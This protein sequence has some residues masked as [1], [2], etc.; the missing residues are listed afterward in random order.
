MILRFQSEI[1]EC[2]VTKDFDHGGQHNMK[3]L[4]CKKV[5]KVAKIRFTVCYLEFCSIIV[6]TFIK[7]WGVWNVRMMFEWNVWMKCSN[8]M[9]EWYVRMIFSND[10]FEWNVRFQ[11]NWSPNKREKA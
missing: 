4:K 10:M 8:D 6:W 3:A 9:F 5:Q 1:N 2:L 11:N 7:Y